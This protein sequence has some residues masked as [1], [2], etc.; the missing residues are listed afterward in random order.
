MKLTTSVGS[1]SCRPVIALWIWDGSAMRPYS[2]TDAAS[3]GTI[4]RIANSAVPAAR[5]GISP[6][7]AECAARNQRARTVSLVRHQ[8]DHWRTSFTA[9][10]ADPNRSPEALPVIDTHCHLDTAAFDDDREQ[11]IARAAAAG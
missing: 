7:N 8:C 9:T 11:V 3:V 6:S 2:A 1:T 10:V 5:I 4:A